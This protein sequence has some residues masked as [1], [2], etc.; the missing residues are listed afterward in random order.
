MIYIVVGDTKYEF[1]GTVSVT[2]ERHYLYE[3][4]HPS[5]ADEFIRFGGYFK[6]KLQ[7][8]LFATALIYE[9]LYYHV[10][11]E[12]VF[13]IA[14]HTITGFQIRSITEQLP[15]PSR[16][17]YFNDSVSFSLTSAKYEK[18]QKFTAPTEG[19]LLFFNLKWNEKTISNTMWNGNTVSSSNPP[20]IKLYGGTHHVE[21]SMPTNA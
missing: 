2:P 3:K 18:P 12:E 8:M 14:W 20:K 10:L 15:Y 5:V 9:E 21:L 1:Q 7:V 4:K 17:R 16:L 6:D 19:T 13:Y 11:Q